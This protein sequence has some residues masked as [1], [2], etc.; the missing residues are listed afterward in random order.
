MAGNQNGARRAPQ[1]V[2]AV[3][4]IAQNLLQTASETESFQPYDSAAAYFERLKAGYQTDNAKEV[5]SGNLDRWH[6]FQWD[7]HPKLLA[8]KRVIVDW[9][10]TRIADGG[11]ILAGDCGCGKSHIARAVA[12]ARGPLAKFVN[13]VELIKAIQATY[14]GNSPRSE[15][16]LLLSLNSAPL[17]IYD[18]LGTYETDNAKWIQP[19]YYAIFNGRKEAGRATL[20]TTN[21]PLIDHAG[22]S[23]LEA[24]VGERTFSRL[25]G[26][27]GS[28]EYLIDL[29]GVPDYRLRGWKLNPKGLT[30]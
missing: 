25:L 9:S 27:V 8:A 13:E 7:A 5:V 12:D 17:L 29:F 24:R 30:R 14:G 6:S 3:G 22:N 4:D 2:P 23:P 1:V 18:D 10:K 21:L 15:E 26:Q 11:L 19:I 16:S 20:I 28:K